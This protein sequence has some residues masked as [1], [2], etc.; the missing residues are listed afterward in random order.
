[1]K[2]SRTHRVLWLAL[3]LCAPAF[4]AGADAWDFSGHLAVETRHFTQ[5]P[6]WPGQESQPGRLAIEAVPE[7]RWRSDDGN[8]RAS[9]IPFLRWDA[10]DEER[11]LIDLREAYW[12]L[13]FD[14]AELL[15]GINTV[16]WGVTESLHLVDIVNQTDAVADI[17]GEAKLG[18][19]MV[20]LALQTEWGLL[21][22]YALPYFRERTFAGGE[23]RLRPP[24]V[25]DGDA[26][27]YE[28]EGGQQHVDLA[29]RYSHYLG[30]MDIGLSLFR[31]TSREPR[32]LPDA[33]GI[34]L[35]PVYDQITQA[36]LDLQLTRDAWL[37]KLETIL[38]DG[39]DDRFAAAVGGFEY[40]LYQIADSAAD[41]GLI[42]E[43]Q[44]DGRDDSEPVTLSDNDL[45]LG[46]RWALNDVQDTSVLAGVGYDLD[47]TDRFLNV[48]A[49]RRIGERL[50][51]ELRARLFAA[52]SAS[53]PLKPIGHDDYVEL[54]LA[55]YF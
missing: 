51:I 52:G 33:S 2:H 42:V 55:W 28:S 34:R 8:Q 7:A 6:Q 46:G 15:V 25:V 36:G 50:V 3:L 54:Q 38:R 16:F 40:T 11:S 20:N 19:P 53:S 26:A 35:I 29:L 31:G 41:L 1:M 4:A 12:A 23:G 47:T 45:F 27:R 14:S 24:L 37:W 18:Q 30:D 39:H 21:S 32:L 44:Y 9:L 13:R 48:E 49:E 43:Y 22:L 10:T 5:G 17:D